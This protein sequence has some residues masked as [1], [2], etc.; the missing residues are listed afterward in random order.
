[1]R[2]AALL[3]L[4]LLFGFAGA[5]IQTH[6]VTVGSVRLP[7]GAA[8]ALV[9]IVL[10][11]RAGAWWQGSRLGAITFS[12]GWLAATLMMGSETGAGD[13][14]LSSGTRQMGYLIGGTILL[15]AACGFPLLPE[16]DSPE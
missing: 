9:A 1:M 3:V 5:L 4:G 13:L 8:L 2:A 16:E 7:T 15:A 12:I 10:V 14:I 11:A 6:T